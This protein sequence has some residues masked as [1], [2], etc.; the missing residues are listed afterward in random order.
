M[1]VAILAGGFGTRLAEH[2]DRIPKPMVPI[3]NHPILWHIM[4][5]YETFGYTDFIVAAGY[6]SDVIKDYFVDYR[7]KR[8]D[9]TVSLQSGDI[10]FHN[11]ETE[12]WKVTVLDTGLESD[13]GWRVRL[14]AEHLKDEAFMLTYGD[15]VANVDIDQLIE[16]HRSHGKL[17]TMTVVRPPARFG[18]VTFEG[19]KV[20]KFDEKPQAGDGWING[21]F[22]VLEPGVKEFIEGNYQWEREPLKKLA[23]A[24][25]LMAYRHPGF[26]K[27]M[28]TLND[29]R[30]L[31]SMWRT[32][33]AEWRTWG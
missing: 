6:K 15:G 11:G 22:F 29:L 33:D 12:D 19:D 31:E 2:T 20:V 10:T 24:G 13:S 3:G 25:Q 18:A 14:V 26:W 16:F 8:G 5:G 30:V 32:E 9:I 27:N 1:K 28:D 4:K 21:G 23:E 7:H 17:V